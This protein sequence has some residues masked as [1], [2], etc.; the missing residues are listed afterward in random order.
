[1]YSFAGRSH[2]NPTLVKGNFAGTLMWWMTANYK[3]VEPSTLLIPRVLVIMLRLCGNL[4]MVRSTPYKML[5]LEPYMHVP[6]VRAPTLRCSQ[7]N[8]TCAA[9]AQ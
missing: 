4:G 1:M 7:T 9:Y 6:M 5:L 2:L 8:V 3:D